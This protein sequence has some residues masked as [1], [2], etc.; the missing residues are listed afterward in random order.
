MQNS[1][2]KDD[3][4]WFKNAIIYEVP[5]RA[6]A[7]SNGD[8]IGDF[9]GLTEKLDYLQ[10]LGVTAL[11]LL[12]FFPS[13][14][15]DDGYD[16]ADYTS[17]NPIYGTLEDFKDFLEAAHQ[18]G[19]RV[20]IE[21]IVNHT[22]DQHPWF[23]RARRSPKGSPER[24]FYVWSE[25]PE[26]YQEAR[27]IFQDF[28]TSNWAWDPLAKAYYWH[29]FYSHQPDLNY[30]NPAVR[31]AVIEVLDFWLA[32]GVDG[33]RMDAV[34]YLY[35]REGTNC[36]N[37]PETH[38]FL[39]QLRTHV[40]E[41]F[42]NRMLL[43]E[44]N[45]WP[46]DAAQYYGAGDECHM[47][48]HFPLMPR[49][50]MSLRMEDSFPI[51]DILH[52]TPAIPDNCQWGLFLRN[53]DE[54]TLEMVSDEDRD[55]M[56]RVY[57]QDPEMRVNLGI[58]R[59]LAPLLGN[60]RRQI[61]LLNSL[62]LSLPGTP[63][64]YYGDEIGMGDNVY[65]G[66]RNGVRTPMQWSADRNAGFSRAN[67]HKLYLPVIVESEYH[68]EAINVEAQRANP[69]SLWY[70]MKRLM[71]TRKRFQALGK[72]T[73]E[74]L[75]PENRKVLAFTRTYNGEHILVVANLSRFVQTVELDLSAFKGMEP[76]E[77]FGRTHFPSIGES[78]Y[79]LSVGPYTFY[80][81]TLQMQLSELQPAKPQAELPTLAVSG[82]WQNVFS[83]AQVKGTLESILANYLYNCRWFGGKARIVQS[84]HIG[85]VIPVS[86]KD[87]ESQLV[88]L[89]VDY[90]QGDPQTYLLL[91]AYAEGEQAALIQAE[92]P[93]AV[94]ARLQIQGK[95]SAGI[96][97]DAVVDK[98]FLSFPLEAIA[99]NQVYKGK[100]GQLV[101]TATDIF[102]Q[103]KEGATNLE[104]TL[105]KGEQSNTS[106]I[107]G[108]RF[109]LKL[110]RKLE[111]GINPDLEIGLFL[112]AKKRLQHFASIAGS[113]EY[114]R[115]KAEPMTVGIL[116]EFILDTRSSWEYTLDSLRDYFDRVTV[117]QTEITEIPIPSGSLLDLQALEIPELAGQTIGSY[118]ASAQLLGQRTAEL[119]IALASDAD[120]PD[121]APEAFST[122]Y[123]R[124][125]YQSARNLTG[126]VL[127]LLKNRLK[128]LPDESQKL[129]HTVLERQE[130]L[131][132]R[133]QLVLNQKIT[134]KRTRCHGDYHL[135]Q[136]LYTGKDFIIIDFEGEPARSLSERRMKRSALRDVAGMLQSFNYAASMG[137]RNE[138]ESGM[139]REENLPMMEQWAEFWYTWVSAAFLNSYL[140]VA[141]ADSFLPKTKAELQV[142][143]DA[144]V[145]EKVIYELGYELNNRPNWV[146]IPLR[147]ILQLH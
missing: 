38:V 141:G 145:L 48:F 112:G 111:E 70:S 117:Q 97:F 103:I 113:L 49:L 93:Q 92:M 28:E 94:V 26:K 128:S 3:A 75:H 142:L 80:W 135:G 67:P 6:F 84:A 23:Q 88:W 106:V 12:P 69:N 134:A 10:D 118:L 96:L 123:Q 114:R 86:Y 51:S 62:L 66:D 147:R 82:Q 42:P 64:L 68:Y 130:Q 65:V 132:G 54:L 91:L 17:V 27:I 47:N 41:K 16:I 137:L 5:V 44:A 35:E 57:A 24:D 127:L 79:F 8:G 100:A 4:L 46:E 61:E 50:F 85:E 90:T 105:I 52:Q 81:F 13:P 43:A 133:Y 29:R 120:N 40:D 124:S 102:E 73:F 119:H 1:I 76:V 9:R 55:Y 25:T 2:L 71:A 34:P 32:M 110:F 77:I 109:I 121:F 107:Y 74:L 22:S 139:I 136:V 30:D 58:R 89:Q 18:R 56:Y 31:Q 37:L 108:D 78:P 125:I 83:Q 104:P 14:L 15:K 146:H 19:I 126:Q 33:L 143:L 59:R 95:E 140:T 98:H 11:W 129:A 116:Q 138:V 45:Q 53:H 72:G 87:L 60:D 20:I 144:Y 122:F 36:E 21:L 131:M 7:D 63:V 39:K 101:A 99:Q 115:P